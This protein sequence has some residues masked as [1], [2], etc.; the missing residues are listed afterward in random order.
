ME[1]KH[2]SFKEI[3]FPSA[4]ELWE[5]ISPTQNFGLNTNEPLMY[6]GQ[7]NSNWN[8]IPTVLRRDES[9]N[10]IFPPLG[11][12]KRM[13]ADMMI[14]CELNLINDF[15]EQCDRIGLRMPNDSVEFRSE[16]L[17]PS[18]TS[19][20][21]R[22]P[23]KWPNP[24]I[25][26]L[27][28]MAQHHGVPTRLLDWTHIPYTA[29]YFAVSSALANYKFWK[30][31]DK[32]AIWVIDTSKAYKNKD[33]SIYKSPG[34]TSP[35]LAAQ[36]GVFTVHPHSGIRNSEFEIN[37]LEYYT[38]DLQMPLLYKLTTSVK[39]S[40]ELLMLCHK[41]GFSAV[42][43]YPSADGAGRGAIDLL[44]LWNARRLWENKL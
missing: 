35:H 3:N 9:G 17:D 28:A 16:V 18:N 42:D 22:D 43:I 2:P 41:V 10:H 37:S 20:Y 21:M 8:L 29:I 26:N 15:V 40:A 38:E 23:H 36:S 30:S 6:R 12:T 5:A 27:M 13:P 44:N 14:F 7:A 24:R 34:S 11:T 32:L 39:E 1:R 25:L 31:D 4:K 19:L 33:I